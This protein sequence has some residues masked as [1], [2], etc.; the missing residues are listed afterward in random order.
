MRR[1]LND[2]FLSI[3]TKE[4]LAT[5]PDRVQVYEG[6]DKEK[7]RDVLSTRPVVQDEI[8]RWKKNKSPGPVEK[9]PRVLKECRGALSGP[10][11]HIFKMSVDS[12][13][14]PNS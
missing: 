3:F 14:V 13:Y 12:G 10:L 5:L 2:Y 9:F 6:E 8:G 7:L 11:A 4:N 1:M